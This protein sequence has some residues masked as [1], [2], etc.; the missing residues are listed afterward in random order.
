MPSSSTGI[1][2]SGARPLGALHK[3]VGPELVFWGGLGGWPRKPLALGSQPGGFSLP[4]PCCFHA[5]SLETRQQPPVGDVG[6]FCVRCRSQRWAVNLWEDVAYGEACRQG[7]G[8]GGNC[9]DTVPSLMHPLYA[10]A[11]PSSQ[12]RPVL[13]PP[14]G[15]SAC[16]GTQWDTMC[17][18]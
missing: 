11:V 1:L 3:G 9:R 16:P 2:N 17:F 5:G 18:L 6:L 10:R 8:G 15:S 12:S 13:W 14:T 7:S 4:M